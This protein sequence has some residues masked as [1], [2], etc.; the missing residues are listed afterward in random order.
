MQNC[1]WGCQGFRFSHNHKP[2]FQKWLLVHHVDG[3]VVIVIVA[4]LFILHYRIVI[5][6]ISENTV[7]IKIMWQVNFGYRPTAQAKI[8]ENICGQSLQG[9]VC[10][11]M[12]DHR[13]RMPAFADDVWIFRKIMLKIPSGVVATSGNYGIYVFYL[14]N[15]FNKCG[16]V[17]SELQQTF[18]NYR[19]QLRVI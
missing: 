11:L 6:Y 10:C 5:Q 14:R 18:D 12:V 2:V 1:H 13:H 16:P 7:D 3:A 8:C 19:P 9:S 4:V 15:N 17:W